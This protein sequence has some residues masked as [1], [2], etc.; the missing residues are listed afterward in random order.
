MQHFEESAN[1]SAK[2]A[3]AQVLDAFYLEGRVMCEQEYAPLRDAMRRPGVLLLGCPDGNGRAGA[4]TEILRQHDTDIVSADHHRDPGRLLMRIAWQWR[5][6]ASEAVALGRR[7]ALLADEFQAHW[8]MALPHGRPQVAI[9]VSRELHCLEDLLSRHRRGELACDIAL[10]VSNH[11][12]AQS[13]AALHQI[14][15]HEFSVSRNNKAEIER[16]QLELLHRH[17]IDLVVLARY[18]QILSPDFVRCYRDR[19]INVH[20]SLLPAF[21]GAKP[22]QR[23][24]ERGVRYIGATSHYVTETLD[25][26][27]IIEQEAIRVP[28]RADLDD[29]VLLGRDLE[30]AVLFHAVRWHLDHRILVY[31]NKATVFDGHGAGSPAECL[32]PVRRS[33]RERQSHAGADSIQRP[34]I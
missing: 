33:L 32:G 24:F 13:L 3:A 25:D 27:P 1:A 15:F 2:D 12:T 22:Y 18:M 7:F 19:I 5:N 30:K 26:G 17:R 6:G 10:I 31:G 21:C 16:L 29:F 34:G 4:V 9:F 20:H 11:P 28:R 14:S 8:R 23:A